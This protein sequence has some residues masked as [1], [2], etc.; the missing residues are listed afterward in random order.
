MGANQQD[1]RFV[2][3]TGDNFPEKRQKAVNIMPLCFFSGKLSTDKKSE[4]SLGWEHPQI[5]KP[6]DADG[7]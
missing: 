4:P 3:M 7:G 5:Q 1:F 2:I 6:Q